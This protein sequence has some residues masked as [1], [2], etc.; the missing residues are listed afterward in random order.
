M[1]DR[2]TS[3]MKISEVQYATGSPLLLEACALYQDSTT[4]QC[5]AQLKWRNLDPRPVKAVMIELDGYDAFNQKLEPV[6]FQYD[7]LMATQGSD[8]GS[9]VPVQIRSSKMVRYDT[10]LKAVSFSEGDIWR[11][12]KVAV[13]TKLPESLDQTLEGDLLDQYKRDL[14]EMGIVA[15]A[16]H[17]TQ[18]AMGLWQCGCGSWQLEGTPCLRCRATQDGLREASGAR[19]LT[20]H[21]QAYKEEQERLRIEAERKAEEERIARQK[22][23]EERK[24]KEEEERIRREQARLEAEKQA[25]LM[26]QQRNKKIGIAAACI[27][28]VAGAGCAA[29]FYFIPQNQYNSAVQMMN[30]GK[31]ADASA[32][33]SALGEFSDASERINEPYYHQAEELLKKGDYDAANQAFIQAGSFSNATERIGEPYYVQ[34]EALLAAG[35]YVGASEAFKLAGNYADA[36]DRVLEPYYI[37]A[38]ALLAEGKID[39]ASEAFGALGDY[40][41]SV[42]RRWAPYAEQ[43]QAML[44]AGN[45]DD[46]AAAYLALYERSNYTYK[47]AQANANE[48]YYQKAATLEATGDT[49][50]ALTIYESIASYKDSKDKSRAIHMAKGNAALST[51]NL[52][53]ARNEFAACGDM[54]EALTQ[55]GLLDRYE[56][57]V[58]QQAVADYSAARSGFLA[59][60]NYLDALAQVDACNAAEYALAEQKLNNG[61]VNSAYALYMDLGE[62]GDSASKAKEISDAYA[63]AEVLLNAGDYDGAIEAFTALNDYQDS[64]EKVKFTNYQKACALFDAAAYDEAIAIFENLGDYQESTAKVREACFAKAESLMAAGDKKAAEAAYALIPDYDGVSEKLIA[65][66][67]E[68]GNEALENKDYASA[69]AYY[70]NVPQTDDIKALEYQLAQTCYDDGCYEYATKAY[71]LLGQYELSVSKLPV[72]RYAWANQ[73]FENT[74]Y[75]AA[76]EQFTILGNST[77]SAVRAKESLLQLGMQQMNAKDYDTAKGTFRAVSGYSNADDMVKECD[78]RA[79]ADLMAD[80]RYAEAETSFK[81][82][83]NYSDSETQRKECIYLQGCESAAKTDYASAEKFFASISDYKDSNDQKKSCIYKQ[84][85]ALNAS[86][87]YAEAEKR[88]AELGEY[89]DAP[90]KVIICIRAQADA[91]FN[92]GDYAGAEVIYARIMDID[93]NGIQYK[94][95]RLRQGKACINTKDYIGALSFVEGLDYANSETL[96]G[97]CYDALG[98]AARAEGNVEEAVRMYSK[99]IGYPGVQETLYDIAKDFASTN[100]NEKA[101][102]TFWACGDYE[103]ARIMLGELAGLLKANGK[104]ATALTAYYAFGD[105]ASASAFAGTVNE[106]AMRSE[107]NGYTI[108]K[109]GLFSTEILYQHANAKIENNPE[110]AFNIFASIVDYKDVSGILQNDTRLTV[111]QNAKREEANTLVS[112]YKY[113][114]ALKIYSALQACGLPVETQ[115]N[116]CMLFDWM[117]TKTTTVTLGVYSQTSQHDSSPVTWEYLGIENGKALFISQKCLDAGTHVAGKRY[118]NSYGPDL[119]V[120]QWCSTKKSVM[121]PNG[122]SV[123]VTLAI[124]T[125]EILEKYKGSFTA[126]PA[127]TE[128]A[129]TQHRTGRY[130]EEAYW[131]STKKANPISDCDYFGYRNGYSETLLDF[132]CAYIRPIMYIDLSAESYRM[133]MEQASEF[134]MYNSSGEAFDIKAYLVDSASQ[135]QTVVDGDVNTSEKASSH[136]FAG[137]YTGIGKGIGGDVT[138]TLSLNENGM[139]IDAKIDASNETSIIGGAAAGEIAARLSDINYPFE[140]DTVAGATFTSNAILDALEQIREQVGENQTGAVAGSSDIASAAASP[141]ARTYTGTAVGMMGNVTVTVTLDDGG[142]IIDATIDASSETPGFGRDAADVITTQLLESVYPFEV[143]TFAGAT[144]TSNA[145]RDALSQIRTQIDA[146]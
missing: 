60:G 85:D 104:N 65:L 14:S 113:Q 92:I 47:E 74:E 93:D 109:E 16:A 58:K 117:T 63:A 84:A 96:T 39:E 91:L 22:A 99:A 53:A 48:C 112:Q 34:A 42:S 135:N 83:N 139:V 129:N 35:N 114:E 69:L 88:Y 10:V 78:Y 20:Q 97:Q 3:L 116:M 45:Y 11:A 133:L 123:C 50:A 17:S 15:A 56:A 130:R 54:E 1:A 32:A 79:A 108:F 136:S 5:I 141:S 95:C 126:S 6:N 131:T 68:L 71:E 76:A 143:D 102:E 2:L 90:D 73:L 43:A 89:E 52:A 144:I 72:A 8:F 98:Y 12:E 64:A 105:R 70:L 29:K 103:P 33:F 87:K 23:E 146:K 128:Y 119:N 101:I 21:L 9:K 134:A 137:T 38:E 82:L 81:S 25:Q 37:Q 66:R 51:M 124:P 67:T 28:A 75:A 140:V 132:D 125:Q 26:K 100:Q 7:G 44:E 18:T 115:I 49:D 61:E 106:S 4:G 31:Y 62:Y 94:E 107:L 19:R 59:L 36:A 24:R 40:R 77:D 30:D 122:R 127:K 118:Y 57:S 41:D 138:V 121:F 142:K 80:G 13:Y 120:E 27:L 55:L 145:I 46:A 111:V 110:E 86:G